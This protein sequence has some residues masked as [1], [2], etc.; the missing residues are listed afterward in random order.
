MTLSTTRADM[1][2]SVLES[3]V[4]EM[5]E[6]VTLFR[7]KLGHVSKICISGGM[8][9]FTLYNQLQA[10]VYGSEVALYPN[11]E[12][13]S[14]GAWISA[15]VSCGLYSTYDEA[16]HVVQPE[17]SETIFKPDGGQNSFYTALARKRK[18]IYQALQFIGD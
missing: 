17:G 15:A 5:G 12:S 2:R 6:N 1:A 18:K 3:I 9:K 14:L 8:T 13:P 10:D 16:F 4:M 7:E 11:L